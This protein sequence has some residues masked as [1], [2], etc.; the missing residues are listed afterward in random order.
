MTSTLDKLQAVNIA[1]PRRLIEAVDGIGYDD[2]Q[3]SFPFI[4][5]SRGD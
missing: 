4:N 1:N 3:V 5:A 2:I